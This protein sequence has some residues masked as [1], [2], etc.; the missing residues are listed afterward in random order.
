MGLAGRQTFSRVRLAVFFALCLCAFVASSLRAADEPLYHQ[1]PF[2]RIVLNDQNNNAVIEVAPLGLPGRVVPKNLAPEERLLFHLID[3]PD[4]TYAVEW[5]EIAKVEFFEQIL[6]DEALQLA[7]RGKGNAAYDYFRFLFAKY[8]TF[9]GLES[10]YGDFL[11]EEAKKARRENNLPGALAMLRELHDRQPA[12]PGLDKAL[13]ITTDKLLDQYVAVQDYPA[14]RQLLLGL[15]ALYP[16]E[17]TVAKW[18]S[19]LKKA[20]AGFFQAATAAVAAGEFGKADDAARRLAQVWPELPGAREL[21]QSL[22]HKFPR[23]VVGVTLSAANND[24]QR[25][26]D[27]AARRSGR[28]VHRRLTEF[29]GPGPQ[30]GRYVCPVGSLELDP[31]RRQLAV[32]LLPG[33]HWSDREAS[34]SSYDVS[35]RLLAMS[36]VGNAAYRAE[37]AELFGEMEVQSADV[38]LIRLT[39]PHLRPEA[40]LQTIL[41][42]SPSGVIAQHDPTDLSQVSNGP[43]VLAPMLGDETIYRVHEGYAAPG[44]RH[45][46]EIAERTYREINRAVAAL[47]RGEIQILDRVNPWDIS[48]VRA[49]SG[50]KLEAYRMPLVH[51]LIPNLRRSLMAQ[52][53]VRRALVY[54]IDR[55]AILRTLT[56]GVDLPGCQVISGPFPMRIGGAKATLATYDETIAPRA[57]D[58]RLATL[59]L[60]DAPAATPAI[61]LVLAYPP[62]P[63]ARTACTAIRQQ[64]QLAGI[65]LDLKELSPSAASRPADDVDLVYAELAVWEPLVDARRVLGEDGPTGG[66]SPA[67]SLALRQL[68]EAA[69]WQ[70]ARARVRQI[71]RLAHEEAAVIALW[72]LSDHFAYRAELKAVGSEPISLYENVEQWAVDFFY[73]GQPR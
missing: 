61:R 31:K 62:H 67:M 34:L 65:Q 56:G 72:Q 9:P 68:A 22:Y 11:Y 49:T 2:D 71:H 3:Q 14:A 43:Y 53:S 41:L 4:K 46:Q 33:L 28:L 23:V 37:W 1:E 57:Y 30:G 73:P 18:E 51:C 5:Q 40:L 25:I 13:G 66:C 10:A 17:P 70:Q 45:P 59:L 58:P 24:P 15:A 16:Q 39:R 7:A 54:A 21:A 64:L 36:T 12:R 60:R 52:R 63:I 50:V 35:R 26:D 55:Q 20:A 48:T 19:Q 69:D 47:R 32:K 6:L 44:S 29:V 38:F 42:P 27:W 8:P